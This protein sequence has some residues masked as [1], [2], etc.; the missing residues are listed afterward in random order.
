M[1]NGQVHEGEVMPVAPQAAAPLPS[2]L[3]MASNDGPAGVDAPVAAPAVEPASSTL[4]KKAKRGRPPTAL[5][6]RVNLIVDFVKGMQGEAYDKLKFLKAAKLTTNEKAYLVR[7]D[8][9][10]ELYD[11]R[12]FD[13]FMGL[14]LP[15]KEDLKLMHI[16]GL[17]TGLAKQPLFAAKKVHV[18]ANADSGVQIQVQRD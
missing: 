13:M 17:R 8:T 1:E 11:A 9:F 10:K 3:A 18:E 6:V 2:P 5:N 15:T 7:H 14:E 12:L 16:V 4:P